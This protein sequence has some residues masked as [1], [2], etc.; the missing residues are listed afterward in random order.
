MT[1]LSGFLEA[2]RMSY[3]DLE[4]FCEFAKTFKPNYSL[5]R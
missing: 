2:L 1:K 3:H 4:A 5:L